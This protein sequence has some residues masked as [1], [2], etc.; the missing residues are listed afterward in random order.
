MKNFKYWLYDN[1]DSFTMLFFL[2]SFWNTI[3]GILSEFQIKF[4][5]VFFAG[6]FVQITTIFFSFLSEKF[7]EEDLK[8]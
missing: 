7:F 8:K 2:A 3:F 5:F 4:S 1:E 6:F